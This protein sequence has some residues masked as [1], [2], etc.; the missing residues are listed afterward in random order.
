M[1]RTR[2]FSTALALAAALGF[3]LEAGA[4]TIDFDGGGNQHG[5]QIASPTGAVSGVTFTINNTGGGPDRGV[6][7]DTEQQSD[8][9][10]GDLLRFGTGPGQNVGA[11]AG[12]N[13]PTDTVFNLALM[14]QENSTGCDLDGICDDPDDE[15]NGGTIDIIFA[16]PVFSFGLDVLDIDAGESTGGLTFHDS[17]GGNTMLSWTT[18]VG[19]A[20]LG[21]NT[22]NEISP[23][24]IQDLGFTGIEKVTVTFIASG[25]IDNLEIEEE[26]PPVPEPTTAIFLSAALT[27][28]AVFGR[29][30][31]H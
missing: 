5:T 25:A 27:G 8:P 11:W 14:I 28:L 10:D 6:L 19:L 31:T 18:L 4:L 3:G 13:L 15:A 12:G 21:N 29:R 2:I 1:L 23:I 16:V 22:A 20:N 17:A 26:F 7:F 24:S 30:R 9:N